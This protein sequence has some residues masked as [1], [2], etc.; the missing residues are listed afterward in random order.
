MSA[1]GVAAHAV[2]CKTAGGWTMIRCGM[3]GNRGCLLGADIPEESRA[4][5]PSLCPLGQYTHVLAWKE[6]AS[7]GQR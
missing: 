6:S 4:L 3:A 1:T 7:K 2:P 5:L